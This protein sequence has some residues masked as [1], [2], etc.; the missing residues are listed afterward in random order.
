ME[1]T[2]PETPYSTR[3]REAIDSL[4]CSEDQSKEDVDA[5]ELIRK[6]FFGDDTK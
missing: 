1:S 5:A 2:E 3:L 4:T 6:Y